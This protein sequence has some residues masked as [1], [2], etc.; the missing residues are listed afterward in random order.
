MTSIVDLEREKFSLA[1]HWHFGATFSSKLPKFIVNFLS[2]KLSELST[3]I[4]NFL[5]TSD[6]LLTVPFQNFICVYG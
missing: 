4:N 3:F 5:T 2:R 1:S 6:L